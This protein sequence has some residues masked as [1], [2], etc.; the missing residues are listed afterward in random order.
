V[1][2]FTIFNDLGFEG[3]SPGQT[4]GFWIGPAD[5]FKNGAI[6]VTGHAGILVGGGTGSAVAT[7]EVMVSKV[8]I[9]TQLVPG[10]FPGSETLVNADFT[11]VGSAAIRQLTISIG[12]L[13]P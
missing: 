3:L 7:Q 11:N 8:S 9:I 13:S 10:P 1:T 4:T 6:T 12:V 5:V 2:F